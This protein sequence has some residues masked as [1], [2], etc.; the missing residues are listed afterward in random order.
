MDIHNENQQQAQTVD[1]SPFHRGEQELQSRVGLL[2]KMEVM[3]KRMIRSYMPEQHREF[4]AQLPFLIVGSVD[5]QGRPWASILPVNLGEIVSPTPT[6][7]KI[8]SKVIKGDPLNDSYHRK[9]A[10]IGL[11]G[12]EMHS[13]RRN[14][15]NG[16]INLQ[17]NGG[18][19]FQ[20]GQSFG[21]C[22]QYI[23]HKQFKYIRDA[24]EQGPNYETQTFT[25]LDNQTRAMIENAEMFFVASAVKAISNISSEGVDVSHRGGR[26]G[27]I[28]V[29]G[30]TLTIPDYPG[31]NVF[32]TFGN[33]LLNPKAGLLFTDFLSGELTLLTGRVE[34]HWEKNTELENFQGAQRSWTFTLEQGIKLKDALPFSADFGEH[35]PNTL[36]TG[37]WPE[38]VTLTE[39]AKKSDGWQAF[40]LVKRVD[41]AE[42][43]CSFYLQPRDN[44]P[45]LPFKAGM[46]LL[47][48][49]PGAAGEKSLIRP[50]TLSSAPNGQYY[51]ISVK[52][53]FND[54]VSHYLHHHLQ[55]GGRIELKAP[56]GGFHIDP[57]QPRPAVLI[58]AGI[59]ITPMIAMASHIYNESVRLRQQRL[60]TVIQVNKTTNS[61]AFHREF[62][63]LEQLSDRQIRYVSYVSKALQGQQS[64]IEFNGVG[65]FSTD[66]YRQILALDDYD[67]FICGPAGFMQSQYDSLLELGVAD[68]RIFAEAF[69]PASLQRVARQISGVI[70]NSV[71]EEGAVVK[72]AEATQSLVKF[73]LSKV[74]QAWQRG[75]KTLLEIAEALG[76][77]PEFGCRSGS[78]G[79]CATPLI[80]GRISYRTIPA[81]YQADNQVLICCAVPA[82]GA[83]ELV[84]KL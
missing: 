70:E 28:K 11:L 3:G 14:R 47:L 66:V 71:V 13:R 32:N 45:L 58:G 49:V 16:Y 42:G 38:A 15:V 2:S 61:R 50:Y 74:E 62:K 59:G 46:H 33:F 10:P 7:L 27:F 20:V 53:E 37:T 64:G 56:R 78:C 48:K 73:S 36:M 31:N 17:A 72:V 55:V 79:A 1:A 69:G 35:S 54:G 77:A 63:Q 18:V 6:R 80:A 51:R 52:H 19:E 4:Y 84:L 75:D 60:I 23:Q 21:N 44:I 76:L 83:D 9:N 12:I 82:K 65:R 40:S 81:A 24:G 57:T 25:A 68:N 34:L 5:N 8:D 41:E 29:Q 39:Q 22:P 43:I 26:P 30:N 67:F